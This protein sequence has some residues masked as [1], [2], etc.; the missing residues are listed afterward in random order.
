MLISDAEIKEERDE[1]FKNFH[2][3]FDDYL[4]FAPIVVAY[5]MMIGHPEHNAWTFTKKAMINEVIIGLTIRCFR[6]SGL[7]D[8][9]LFVYRKII[10]EMNIQ[11][12]I[13]ELL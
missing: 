2:T 8:S 6:F 12:T 3:H 4:Q 5:G 13:R 1:R 11:T 7:S 10:L 9:V